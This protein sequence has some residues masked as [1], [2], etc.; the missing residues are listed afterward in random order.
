MS[1]DGHAACCAHLVAGPVP[2]DGANRIDTSAAPQETA[3][4]FKGWENG[5]ILLLTNL[6]NRKCNETKKGCYCITDRGTYTARSID[7]SFSISL[8]HVAQLRS[9]SSQLSLHKCLT[10]A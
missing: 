9:V 6:I 4:L 8:G 7:G 2:H 10:N 5:R 1:T 3:C